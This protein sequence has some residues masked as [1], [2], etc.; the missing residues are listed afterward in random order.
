[1]C[2]RV[3]YHKA[4]TTKRQK[5][6]NATSSLTIYWAYLL[7]FLQFSIDVNT[8][9]P[10]I[11]L[12]TLK[13]Q[14][15]GATKILH[16]FSSREKTIWLCILNYDFIISTSICLLMGT[17]VRK[18]QSCNRAHRN[19]FPIYS[20]AFQTDLIWIGATVAV[21]ATRCSLRLY[22][23]S[24]LN[25]FSLICVLLYSHTVSELQNHK[26]TLQ[27]HFYIILCLNLWANL[28]YRIVVFFNCFFLYK[29]FICLSNFFH[30]LFFST[31]HGK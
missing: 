31:A 29:L 27:F 16:F 14:T 4:A 13:R 24:S 20:I 6:P 30:S 7:F 3:D 28:I 26:N 5:T 15:E 12:W 9:I 22:S 25:L 23:N 8:L 10:K 11:E 21:D 18:L 1:M 17:C 2:V 19:A